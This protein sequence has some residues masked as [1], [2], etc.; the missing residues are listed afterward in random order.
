MS[1]Q[2]DPV[3]I[4]LSKSASD[5]WFEFMQQCTWAVGSTQKSGHKYESPI[6]YAMALA[7]AAKLRTNPVCDFR[8]Y[9]IF[10]LTAEEAHEYCVKAIDRHQDG[11]IFPQ[12]VIGSYRADFL[13]LHRASL[14][15]FA[16]IVVECDGHDF[17]ERTKEQATRDKSRDR[18]MQIAGYRVLRFTGSEIWRDAF[19]CAD[20]V[21]W[22]GM[23]SSH[24]ALDA[25]EGA[26][27]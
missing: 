6:E 9:P 7:F 22:M 19:K 25:A 4:Q 17:H 2:D 24:E 12:V 18:E 27:A 23:N 13:M 20:Q 26:A 10:R 21:V 11:G 8:Y 14:N 1:V 15:T 3:I 5:T 16:G